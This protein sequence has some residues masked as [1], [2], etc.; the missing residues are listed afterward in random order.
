[1]L[2]ADFL[3]S[4][5]VWLGG[6]DDLGHASDLVVVLLLRCGCV[7]VAHREQVLDVPLSSPLAPTR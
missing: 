1:M 3:K 7:H 5:H 4:K 2:G 6:V